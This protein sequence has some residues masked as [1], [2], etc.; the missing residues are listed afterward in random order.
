MGSFGSGKTKCIIKSNKKQADLDKI[1]LYAKDPYEVKS[2]FLIKKRESTGP[3]HFN[4]PKDFIEYSNDMQDVYKNIGEY[5]VAKE[6][7]M[8]T[9]FDDMIA[10][11]ISNKKRNSV[12]TELFIRGRKLNIS[13][14]FFNTIIL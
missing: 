4:D 8:L 13:L 2:Q 6:R 9:V 1:Y 12:V 7:K 3:K 14:V 11:M 10:D 5:N